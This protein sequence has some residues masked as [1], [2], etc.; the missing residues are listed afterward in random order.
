MSVM[1]HL[2]ELA[3]AAAEEADA[4]G[5]REAELFAQERADFVKHA[6][7]HSTRVLGVVATGALTWEYDEST[8]G[9]IEAA[10]AWLGDRTRLRFEYDHDTERTAFRLIRECVCCGSTA[11]IDVGSLADL[12]GHLEDECWEGDAA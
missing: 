3:E 5:N 6:D 7:A 12:A 2:P 1:S 9:G 8:V 10:D 4:A 11:R